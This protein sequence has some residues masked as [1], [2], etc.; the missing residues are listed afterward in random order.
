MLGNGNR[1]EA[2]DIEQQPLRP[3]PS[4]LPSALLSL[5]PPPRVSC[6]VPAMNEARNIEWVLERVPDVIDQIILVDGDSTDDT[7]EIARRIRPDVLVVGQQRPGK[8]AALR[9]GFDAADGEVIVMI[10]ADR[11]MDPAEITRFLDRIDTGYDLVKGSRFMTGAGTDD[12]EA[13]RRWGNRVLRDVTNTLYS[14]QFTDLCYGFMAF[15]RTVLETLDLRTDGFE[16]ETEIVVRAVKTGLRVAEVP[17]FEAPRIYGT[18]NL[19]TWRDGG[20]VASTLIRHRF[21]RRS[22]E[23][24]EPSFELATQSSQP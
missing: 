19:R 23:A 24:P 3:A 22:D 1:G 21:T 13:I 16:I 17:S 7:V 2:K 14:C 9:A 15:R 20:R 18:S 8:G 11:S 10:D 5:V 12:M 4:R 6:V